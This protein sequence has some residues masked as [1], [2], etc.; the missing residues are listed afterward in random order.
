MFAILNQAPH[1]TLRVAAPR[2]AG[3]R[4]QQQR[5]LAARSGRRGAHLE[6]QVQDQLARVHLPLPG[7]QRQL[8]VHVT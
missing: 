8:D 2:T 6:R 1:F 3:G 7:K 4:V 5:R